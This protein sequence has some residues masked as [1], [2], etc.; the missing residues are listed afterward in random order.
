ME[1]TL[2]K[3]GGDPFPVN[4][5]LVAAVKCAWSGGT[6]AGPCQTRDERGGALTSAAWSLLSSTPLAEGTGE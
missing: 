6:H 4:R 3:F 5:E 1:H 2:S